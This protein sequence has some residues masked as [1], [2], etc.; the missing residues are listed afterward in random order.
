MSS[1]LSS[2]LEKRLRQ[3]AWNFDAPRGEAVGVAVSGGSDSVAML[4]LLN[5]VGR[6]VRAVTIDHGLR[7]E[8]RAEADHVAT[9]CRD[10]NIPHAII[11][12]NLSST[13]SRLQERARRARY[14]A[15]RDWATENDIRHI[16]VAHTME[17]Q[18]ET[19]L[20][21]LARGSG[22]DGLSGMTSWS[23]DGD[24][25]WVRPFLATRREELR[26]YLH[27][28]GIDWCED[29]SNDDEVYE[30][31][32]IRKALALLEPLG[33]TPVAIHAAARNL[34]RARV[35]LTLLAKDF[36]QTYGREENGDIILAHP[37]EGPAVYELES[38]QRV[39][40]AALRWISGKDYPPRS[41]AFESLLSAIRGGETH[42]LHGCRV[43]ARATVRI[44][45]E[46][47]AVKAKVA[48]T[49]HLWDGRWMLCGPHSHELEIRALGDAVNET[50]WRETKMPR[51]AL[52]ASPAV[53]RGRDLV[54]APLAGLGNGWS[55]TATGRGSFVDFL[56]SR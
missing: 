51:E 23:V 53:W 17:D 21:R 6:D 10:R 26:S 27:A 50:P 9:L 22:V 33:V 12:L 15:L 31:V 56:V 25:V 36:F 2:D 19:F 1:S 5:E 18:A 37:A 52:R 42:T 43:D 44:T 13:G 4:L 39:V 41:S 34:N 20:M 40:K 55:V 35:E 3:I 47:N 7:P 28:R 11:N 45:R 30:R 8:A 29:P 32:R 48:P 46:Y 24:V 38:R 54:A 14:A 49:D 16:G